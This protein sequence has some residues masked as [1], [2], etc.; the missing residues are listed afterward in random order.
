MSYKP[1]YCCECGEK[2]ERAN[3]NLLTNGR[4]CQLC[5]TT[6]GIYD[7]IPKFTLVVGLLL[8]LIGIGGFFRKPDKELAISPN[9][10]SANIQNS[11]KN[12]VSQPKPPQNS[13][14][15]SVQTTFQ[16]NEVSTVQAKQTV[17]AVKQD[18]KQSGNQPN[19]AAEVVYFCGARTKKGMPC[20]RR[21]KN[22]GRCWQHLGQPAMLPP[23][24]LIAS[25]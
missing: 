16:T 13:N 6:F 17:A 8:A 18:D 7:K 1:K 2:I 21:V 5:E 10:F 25:K 12:P 9:R 20:T 15:N 24:K 11:D 4:F 3:W 22:G 23:E 19:A 14:S